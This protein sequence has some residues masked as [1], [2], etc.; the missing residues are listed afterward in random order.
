MH[1]FL[2]KYLE[3]NFG[4]LSQKWNWG[5]VLRRRRHLSGKLNFAIFVTALVSGLRKKSDS[6][7]EVLILIYEKI[8]YRCPVR[9]K[10][11]PTARLELFFTFF[12]DKVYLFLC[13]YTVIIFYIPIFY[14]PFFI[15]FPGSLA[16]WAISRTG[17]VHMVKKGFQ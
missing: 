16:Q 15:L 5:H 4:M 10:I 14:F 12:A 3:W 1:R 8:I 6:E 9:Y 2:M 11:L 7:S 13:H 17:T